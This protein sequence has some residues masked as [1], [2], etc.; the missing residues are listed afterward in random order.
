ML[1][2]SR[3]WRA[4]GSSIGLVPTMGALHAGHLSLVDLARRENDIVVVS[5]FVNPIQFGPGEDFARYPRDP[6]RDAAML[7]AAEVDAIYEPPTEAMYPPGATTRVQVGAVSAPLEGLSR[8]GHFEGVATVVTKLFAAVAPD[9]AYFGQKD[10]QQVAVVRRLAHDLDLGVEIR[11]APIV[12]EADGLAMSSRNVYL[13]PAERVAAASLNAALRLAAEAY[14]AGERDH[15][16]LSEIMKARMAEEP[17]VR[18]D[19]AEVVDAAT[20]EK[21]G[22]LAVVAARVGET[23]QTRLMDNHDLATP[24]PGNS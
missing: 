14:S 15:G 18:V 19:Y 13:N 10:A 1:D 16:R 12:R 6:E 20:F 2:A 4:K 17:L 5:I 3:R 8:P 22:T 11:V 21:P 9:R 7:A 24:F 23:K